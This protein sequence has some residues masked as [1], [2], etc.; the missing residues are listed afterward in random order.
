MTAKT[1]AD[2]KITIRP[3]HVASPAIGELRDRMRAAGRSDLVGYA[4][5]SY[6]DDVAWAVCLAWQDDPAADL[7][8]LKSRA[9][10]ATGWGPLSPD[11]VRRGMGLPVRDAN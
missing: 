5:A 11:D 10:N 1:N 4:G 6:R 7:P 8:T 2:R 9:L 3:N